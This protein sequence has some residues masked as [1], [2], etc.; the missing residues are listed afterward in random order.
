MYTWKRG[1]KTGL[2]YLRT[3]GGKDAQQVTIDPKF[4][5]ELKNKKKAQERE[6][7]LSNA[8]VLEG[9]ENRALAEHI[10]SFQGNKQE[11]CENCS[12]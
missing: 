8:H 11:A 7:Q 1:L 2:Y 9:A 5:E 12:A 6:R 3:K 4:E 10:N